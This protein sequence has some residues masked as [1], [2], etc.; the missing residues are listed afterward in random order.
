MSTSE[1]IGARLV[2]AQGARRNTREL[3]YDAALQL[4]ATHGY[5]RTTLRQ[6]AAAVGIEAASIYSH[7]ESK[8]QL[9]FDLLMFSQAEVE[10]SL[11][12]SL[13]IADGHPAAQLYAATYSHVA[14]H[15][16]NPLQVAV[17]DRSFDELS[18]EQKEIRA[19]RA[20]AYGDVFDEILATGID[21]G[22]FRPVDVRITTFGI[23]ALGTRASRWFRP[24]G[25]YRPEAVGEQYA[26]QVLRSVGSKKVLSRLGENTLTFDE[27]AALFRE[28]RGRQSSRPPVRRT[29]PDE[30]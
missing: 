1:S 28:P 18:D 2:A 21:R 5:R 20:R 14:Y 29:P 12:E 26:D 10:Q 9:F 11:D 15:C 19:K 4:F 27:A 16:R 6:I 30:E 17:L 22:V 24:G 23:I 25:R 8:Q 13:R 7:T 3:I